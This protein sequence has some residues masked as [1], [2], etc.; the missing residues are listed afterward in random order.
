MK[1]TSILKTIDKNSV[2]LFV[3]FFF[4]YYYLNKIIALIL[5][6]NSGVFKTKRHNSVW[7]L[8]N[9]GGYFKHAF[10][11]QVKCQIPHLDKLELVT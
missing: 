5:Q 4:N 11:I 9:K 3:F 1:P 10:N 2:Q 7:K 8:Q 6:I